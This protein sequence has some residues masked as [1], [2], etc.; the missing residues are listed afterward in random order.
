MTADRSQY[1]G[2]CGARLYRRE[3]RE[4]SSRTGCC[5]WRPSCWS[6]LSIVM[7][8]SASAVVA[9]GAVS[10]AVSVPDQAGDV[11][12]ARHRAARRRDARST[13]ASTAS[14]SFIWTVPR[15]GD[16]GARSRCSSARPST[17]R[18]AGSAIGGLGVQP[19]ELAKLVRDLLHRGAA[20][21]ADAPHQRGRLRAGCR[22]ASSSAAWSADSARAGL[23]HGDVAGADRRGDGVRGGPAATATSSARLLA[24]LPAGRAIIVMGAAYR[25]RRLLAFLNPVGRPARRRL[26]DH[27]VAHRRR[28]R[29]GLRAAG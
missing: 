13:T 17:A 2:R 27:P 26:P 5:S 23:R 20:R 25:R 29:R 15:R 10:A 19:S 11:G 4:N 21:A 7:V 14:R 28:H 24:V 12:G 16:A 18:G 1:V 9:D 6:A 8:Y 22:S 3:W